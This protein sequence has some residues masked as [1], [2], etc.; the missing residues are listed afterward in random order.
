[1]ASLSIRRVHNRFCGTRDKA[2]FHV[3]IRERAQKLRGMRDLL[4]VRDAGFIVFYQRDTGFG[5]ISKRDA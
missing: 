2:E 1:M 5:C 4:F 3:G